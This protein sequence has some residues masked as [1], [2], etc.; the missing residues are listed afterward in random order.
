MHKIDTKV[1]RSSID[2]TSSSERKTAGRPYLCGFP[3]AV[4]AEKIV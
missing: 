4:L 2:E 3:F 1:S